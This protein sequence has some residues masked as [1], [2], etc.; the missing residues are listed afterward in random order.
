MVAMAMFHQRLR[1]NQCKLRQTLGRKCY[2]G[3]LVAITRGGGGA[4]ARGV[5]REEEGGGG[6]R[7][8]RVR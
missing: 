4:A 1:A 2:F 8:K 7:S 3:H 6:R 5:P